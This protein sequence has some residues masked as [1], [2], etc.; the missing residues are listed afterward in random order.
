MI[1]HKQKTLM[2][3]KMKK[4]SVSDTEQEGFNR[5][6]DNN[7]K[8]YSHRY[9]TDSIRYRSLKEKYRDMSPEQKRKAEIKSRELRRQFPSQRS[10]D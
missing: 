8:R 5:V 7:Q 3:K 4:P 10:D 2:A 6:M 1:Y 9:S